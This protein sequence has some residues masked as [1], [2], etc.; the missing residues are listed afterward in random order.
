[1]S[2]GLFLGIRSRA[3]RCCRRN[4]LTSCGHYSLMTY[5]PLTALDIQHALW[6]AVTDADLRW[7]RAE[8]IDACAGITAPHN[9]CIMLPLSQRVQPGVC[10]LM[11]MSWYRNALVRHAPPAERPP[12]RTRTH[13]VV[14]TR[15]LG[16]PHLQAQPESLRSANR[17]ALQRS[18]KHQQ[19]PSKFSDGRCNSSYQLVV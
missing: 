18:E 10:T 9:W 17:S 2:D 12:R 15:S 3:S 16:R 11:A 7:H 13:T 14:Q 4:C 6:H 5:R 19:R 8:D 1:M